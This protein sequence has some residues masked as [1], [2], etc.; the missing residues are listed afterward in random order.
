MCLLCESKRLNPEALDA[1][2]G[3]I[4]EMMNSAASTLMISL[5]YRSGLFEAMKGLEPSTSQEIAEAAGLNERYVREWLGAMTCARIVECDPS[6]KR[7]NLPPEHAAML[8]KGG[9]GEC[10]A[11]M[12]QYIGLMGGVE[13]RILDCFFHG[14]GVPYSAFERFHEVMAED[15]GQSVLPALT[16]HILPLVPGLTV[17]LN[18]GIDVLDVGCGR[19]EAMIMLAEQFPRSN[20]WGFD[21]SAEAIAYARE[22]A[23]RLGLRN[24]LFQIRDLATFHEDAPIA[25]F[26]LVTAFDA[27]HDQGRP[28]HMLRGVRRALKPGG[29]FLAQD[30]AADSNVAKNLEHPIGA[31]IYTISCMHCMTVSLAQEGGLGVG[32]AWG[33]QMTI[34]FMEEAGFSKVERHK[35]SHD[36]Q[37]YYYVARP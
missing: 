8:T 35:L 28:D 24:V 32:A 15:S 23:E 37:N 2:G 20:F 5:G 30:I 33:E 1:F 27:I 25:A 14:G 6:G 22:K 19:G 13:S 21:L 34:Q 26:D 7:F 29:V 17:K 3:R 12:A 31:L 4:L 10:M 11:H 36:I 16:D 18:R 9:E